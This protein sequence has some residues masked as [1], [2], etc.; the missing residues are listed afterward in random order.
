MCTFATGMY[1]LEKCLFKPSLLFLKK[2]GL[3]FMLRGM[4]F[5]HIL[6][7]YQACCLQFF[8]IHFLFVF[9]LSMIYLFIYLFMQQPLSSHLLIFALFPLLWE[10]DPK[11][12]I[13]SFMSK[14]ILFMFS[15]KRAMVSGLT[16]R[17]LI[18]FS[19]IFYMMCGN[20]PI[21]LLYI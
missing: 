8:S 6:M 1:S 19:F 11:K 17:C 18:H 10:T 2:I 15:S 3:F 20:A 21:L 9:H 4:N 7:P 12:I 5:S 16:Y 14:S 13:L